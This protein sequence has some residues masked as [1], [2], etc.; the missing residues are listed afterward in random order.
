VR[1]EDTGLSALLAAGRLPWAQAATRVPGWGHGLGLLSQQALTEQF[2]ALLGLA[3]SG[4]PAQVHTLFGSFL[5]PASGPSLQGLLDAA[6]SAE[7]LGDADEVDAA[8][9]RHRL[10]ECAPLPSVPKEFADLIVWAAEEAATGLRGEVTLGWSAAVR[11]MAR[12][13]VLDAPDD[14]LLDRLAVESGTART[15]ERRDDRRSALSRRIMLHLETVKPNCL[16]GLTGVTPESPVAVGELAHLLTAMIVTGE[17]VGPR[18][19][20]LLAAD[21]HSDRAQVEAAVHKATVLWPDLFA[22]AQRVARPF[23]WNG[24]EIEAGTEVLVLSSVLAKGSEHSS[25]SLGSRP[26]GTE[27][28]GRPSDAERPWQLSGLCSSPR[29]CI[30]RELALA[31]TTEFLVAALANGR[32]RLLAPHMN[33]ARPPLSLDPRRVRVDV[34]D[35]GAPRRLEGLEATADE[36]EE[37]AAALRELASDARWDHA[38]GV[39]TRGVLLEHARRCAVAARDVRRVARPTP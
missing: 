24:R 38:D 4:R 31:A 30:T 35:F 6:I 5:L 7:A 10:P 14:T 2:V 23:E 27:A 17:R 36:L 32:P 18:A 29:R 3:R 16:A 9:R 25:Q 22:I 37:H 12:R 34:S 33:P 26:Q 1:I 15:D 28:S 8:G 19:L 20:A 21:G 13:V 39:R 11:R